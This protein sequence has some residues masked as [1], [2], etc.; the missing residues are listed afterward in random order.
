MNHDG[1]L[2]I[3]FLAR[4]RWDVLGVPVQVPR[5]KVTRVAVNVTCGYRFPFGST[6]ARCRAPSIGTA[7]APSYRR[8][9]LHTR[10]SLQTNYIPPSTLFPVPPHP[11][12]SEAAKIS[13]KYAVTNNPLGTVTPTLRDILVLLGTVL[14][15][16]NPVSAR[17]GTLRE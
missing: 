9:P 12:Q 5:L 14:V 4:G 3:I 11:L 10:V 1:D 17:H 15:L 13:H 6:G 16:G 7:S 8:R 2:S